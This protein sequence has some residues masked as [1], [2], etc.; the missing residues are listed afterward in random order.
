MPPYTSLGEI[1]N[2]CDIVLRVSYVY[3]FLYVWDTNSCTNMAH[4][5]LLSHLIISK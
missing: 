1:F 3:G 2:S 4:G 5:M